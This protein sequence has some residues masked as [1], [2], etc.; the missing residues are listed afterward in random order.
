MGL[1]SNIKEITNS[2]HFSICQ[3]DDS[4]IAIDL[5]DYNQ[6]YKIDLKKQEVYFDIEHSDY[7][8]DDLN[9]IE[10]FMIFLSKHIGEII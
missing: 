7:N 8:T 3:M 10:N 2:S 1:F 6:T 9:F 5:W 4:E